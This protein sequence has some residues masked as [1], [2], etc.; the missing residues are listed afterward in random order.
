MGV[1]H[2]F[3]PLPPLAAPPGHEST[4]DLLA[5]LHW[6]PRQLTIAQALGCPPPSTIQFRHAGEGAGRTP[7]FDTRA[8]NDWWS[9]FQSLWLLAAAPTV[10][11]DRDRSPTATPVPFVDANFI[12][13]GQLLAAFAWRSRQLEVATARCGFPP[14]QTHRVSDADGN[15]RW[16]GGYWRHA[17]ASW[18][19]QVRAL[20]PRPAA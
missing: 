12:T 14:R 15:T 5:R 11:G 13:E 1:M 20:L 19:E 3:Q 2:L 4:D 10:N 16:L 17:V 9:D 8:I 7:Y 18:L 6:S